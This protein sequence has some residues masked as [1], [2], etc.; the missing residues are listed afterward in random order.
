MAWNLLWWVKKEHLLVREP[1][2]CAEIWKAKRKNV[3]HSIFDIVFNYNCL[4][5]YWRNGCSY[6]KT[7]GGRADENEWKCKNN[8]HILTLK[9]INILTSINH[10][11][12]TFIHNNGIVKKQQNEKR[13]IFQIF[14]RDG[15]NIKELTR[16][17]V[18]QRY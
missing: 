3:G 1:S 18:Q 13:K 15:N 12:P 11:F 4:A 6:R 5:R 16:K 8:F 17:R 10:V 2:R 9:T 7:R 14:K